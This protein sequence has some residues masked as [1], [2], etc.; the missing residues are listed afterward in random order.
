MAIRS[1]PSLS[2]PAGGCSK[3]PI[4][5]A[6]PGTFHLD[7]GYSEGRGAVKLVILSN[8]C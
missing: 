2:L 4:V 8:V 3:Y 1:A 5:S 6:T 7:V